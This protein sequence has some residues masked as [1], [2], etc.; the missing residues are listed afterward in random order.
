MEVNKEDEGDQNQTQNQI[1]NQELQGKSCKGCLYYSSILKSKARN[2]LC[3]G[4]SRTFQQV[5][6]HIVGESEI[7]ASKEGRSLTDFKYACVGY[8]LY[9]DG[10]DPS[11]DLQEKQAEL[12]LC[13]GIELL[14][15]KSVSTA[16]HV[17]TH[18]HNK[19]DNSVLL[20]RFGCSEGRALILHPSGQE[21]HRLD[22]LQMFTR[23]ASL[24]G[25]GV[26]RNMYRVGNYMKDNLD[27]ILY[28]YRKR[29]NDTVGGESF[30]IELCSPPL[31]HLIRCSTVYELIDMHCQ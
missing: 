31:S 29:P 16:D 5:P 7:E 23:N 17:P 3:V 25:S 27:D 2:P 24:V 13:I 28:P 26:A 11:T 30:G 15:D 22:I 18:V 8:S 19:E 6:G 1:K 21:E 4:V 14:V 20:E 12:P 10:K 9:L